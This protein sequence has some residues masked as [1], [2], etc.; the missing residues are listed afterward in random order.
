MAT[1]TLKYNPRNLLAR[2]TIEYILSLGVFKSKT[3]EV[4]KTGLDKAIDE[5]NRGET[6]LC[7]DFEDYL[8]K[9][10]CRGIFARCRLRAYGVV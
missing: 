3:E 7:E 4:S 8:K 10:R 1:L 5:V 6:I 2:R 9:V